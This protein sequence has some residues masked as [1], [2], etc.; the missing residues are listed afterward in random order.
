M[1]RST[2]SSN[3]RKRRK[4]HSRSSATNLE[5]LPDDFVAASDGN[6]LPDD[7]TFTK[8]IVIDAFPSRFSGHGQYK[9]AHG[10]EGPE[11]PEIKNIVNR[12]NALNS[13]N[14]LSAAPSLAVASLHGISLLLSSVSLVSKRLER[15]LLF[16]LCN[17]LIDADFFGVSRGHELGCTVRPHL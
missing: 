7:R 10:N 8:E 9:Y 13:I 1:K 4:T 16:Y 12:S 17:V 15:F 5:D 6:Y 14:R 3:K 2:Q 11:S